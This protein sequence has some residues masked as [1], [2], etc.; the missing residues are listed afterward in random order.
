MTRRVVVPF[1]RLEKEHADDVTDRLRSD[2]PLLV[3]GLNIALDYGE[4]ICPACDLAFWVASSAHSWGMC[5][6]CFSS[7]LVSVEG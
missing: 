2:A 7:R 5:P 1:T 4:A 3:D 6:D